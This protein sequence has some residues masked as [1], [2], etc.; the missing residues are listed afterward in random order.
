MSVCVCVCDECMSVCVYI[1]INLEEYLICNMVYI[2][3]DSCQTL[4]YGISANTMLKCNLHAIVFIGIISTFLHVHPFGASIEY[5]C[6][7]LHRLDNKVCGVLRWACNAMEGS[8]W[9][10]G[11][12]LLKHKK[13]TSNHCK[14]NSF[15]YSLTVIQH[16]VSLLQVGQPSVAVCLGLRGFLGLGTPS[17]DTGEVL[18]QSE[19]IGHPTSK[20]HLRRIFFLSLNLHIRC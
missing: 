10:G 17:A 5:I 15:T 12:T 20:I 7:Y 2:W 1:Y 19:W 18:G 13:V 16:Q 6:S 4:S 11:L 3:A 8:L 14:E 9:T